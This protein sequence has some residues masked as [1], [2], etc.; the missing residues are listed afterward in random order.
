MGASVGLMGGARVGSREL[1]K[2]ERLRGEGKGSGCTL[3]GPPSPATMTS[4]DLRTLS[5]LLPHSH[6]TASAQGSWPL[7]DSSCSSL[8]LTA[9]LTPVPTGSVVPSCTLTAG[10]ITLYLGLPGLSGQLWEGR[11]HGDPPIP[12]SS[13]SAGTKLQILP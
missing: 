11:N 13:E 4:G 6:R 1:G 10:R 7:P 3:S 9:S 8:P 5:S 12:G 2:G